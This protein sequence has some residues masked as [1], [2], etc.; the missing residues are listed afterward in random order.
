[1]DYAK[2]SEALNRWVEDSIDMLTELVQASSVGEAEA[3]IATLA[4]F[5]GEIGTRQAALASL[6]E[7]A[8]S[9]RDEGI[10]TNPYCRFPLSTMQAAVV[11]VTEAVAAR[12]DRLQAVLSAQKQFDAKKKIFADEVSS[13]AAKVSA[14]KAEIDALGKS[15]G[16][17][18]VAPTAHSPQCILPTLPATLPPPF[19]HHTPPPLLPLLQKASRAASASTLAPR[20]HHHPHSQCIRSQRH[21]PIEHTAAPGET[22]WA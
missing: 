10:V 14:E 8:Q 18:I 11:A 1:M 6:A 2:Q 16:T 19:R 13:V 5:G 15:A 20:P 22:R 7:F 9:M 3:E 17:V 21:I 4:S 12:D